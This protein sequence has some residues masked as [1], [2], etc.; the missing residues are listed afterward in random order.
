MT[1]LLIALGCLPFLFGG[2]MNWYMMQHMDKTPPFFLI[3]VLFLILWFDDS[4]I[5]FGL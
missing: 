4:S 5:C 1:M 2:L 3:S